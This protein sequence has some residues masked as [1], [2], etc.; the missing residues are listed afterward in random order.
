MDLR[1]AGLG[2]LGQLLTYEADERLAHLYL[3][4]HGKPEP[5]AR[6]GLLQSVRRGAA[7]W[8]DTGLRPRQ[9]VA[10]IAG[11][12]RNFIAAFLGA[13]WR[14]LVPVA[15]APAPQLGR[16]Q[17]WHDSVSNV[18]RELE[19]AAVA[20]PSTED[21]LGYEEISDTPP[22]GSEP[23]AVSESDIAYLQLSSG[24]THRPK[25]VA[26][27]TGSLTAN[28]LAI[29]RHGLGADPE[30]DLALSWLPLHHDM[31]LVGFVLAPL[32]VGLPAAFLPTAAFVRDPGSWMRA[33]S[34]TGATITFAPNF[35]FSLAARRRKSHPA[36]ALDLSR[37]RVLGCGGEPINPETLKNFLAG[38]QE[39]GLRSDAVLPC[40]G[41]AEAT[42]AVTFKPHRD[43]PAAD[44]ISRR[45]L[46]DK[47]LAVPEPPGDDAID[48]VSCGVPFPDHEVAVFGP[49]GER[50]EERR[51]GE[52]GV[53][54][55]S[56]ASGYT[57]SD[58]L[59]SQLTF[60]PD[61]WLRTGDLG[62]LADGQLYVT[63]R[64]KD[65]LIVNGRNIDPQQVEWIVADLPSVREAGVAAFSVP[66]TQSEDVVLVV[67]SARPPNRLEMSIR[68]AV[69]EH[70]GIG[71][72]TVHIVRPGTI[73]KTTSGKPR[74]QALRARYL[75]GE[76]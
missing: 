66:G 70:L 75:D 63:G 14:G 29:M 67:E 16:R 42:L 72:A 20:G 52:V 48:I 17:A 59:Q 44:R 62:Y 64:V 54:G 28:G 68:R 9:R 4:P 39:S 5:L 65:L 27:T 38:Y 7:W 71:V 51:V 47:R 46:A 21:S 74:R 13:M 45:A 58:A 57:G 25:A 30:H 8:S 37:L 40:Y 1:V 10:V 18:L 60:R 76:I 69:S 34:R 2:L 24:S 56:V 19:I 23:F 49:M 73:P 43:H 50:L 22:I 33:V 15:L 32:T 31:G 11:D 6:D 61:G 35:A 36:E 41:L 53:R 55:P 26:V 12:Q 3:S